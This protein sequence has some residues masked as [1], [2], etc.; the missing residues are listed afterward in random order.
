M[1]LMLQLQKEQV[2]IRYTQDPAATPSAH[3][4]IN[5]AVALLKAQEW[6]KIA[7]ETYLSRYRIC[8]I[9]ED[10]SLQPPP[11]QLWSYKTY[12]HTLQK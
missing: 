4:N 2:W 9:D 10:A 3:I 8:S 1:L 11:V 7:S 12:T 5:N 6:Q